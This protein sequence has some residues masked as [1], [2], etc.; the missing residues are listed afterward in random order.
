MFESGNSIY[1]VKIPDSG[2]K[3]VVNLKELQCDCTNFQEYR[4]PCTHAIV[5]C[6]YEAEDPFNY[7]DWNYSV[8]AY[9]KTYSHFLIPISIEN[10]TSE[11]GVLPPIF[12]KQRGRP[13]TKRIR[14]G[15]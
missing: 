9:R 7:A 1:Q 3:F 11:E 6:R 14:K 5:A 12:K 4:S 13:P 2:R 10:L 8:E 15:A